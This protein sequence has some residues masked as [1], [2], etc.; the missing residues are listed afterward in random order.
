[1]VTSVAAPLLPSAVVID[2]AKLFWLFKAAPI[3]TRVS[4][5][6]DAPPIMMDIWL[7]KYAVVV[8][9]AASDDTV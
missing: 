8:F 3:S 9:S 6:A 7:L 4:N 1:M 2:P 5:V